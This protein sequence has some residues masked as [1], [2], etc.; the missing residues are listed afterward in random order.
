MRN[1]FWGSNKAVGCA[2]AAKCTEVIAGSARSVANDAGLT[3][4][5]RGQVAGAGGDSGIYWGRGRRLRRYVASVWGFEAEEGCCE[6]GVKPPNAPVDNGGRNLDLR[7][8][9]SR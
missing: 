5:F 1:P 4:R 3:D 9:L 7:A 8:M 2:S 6:R